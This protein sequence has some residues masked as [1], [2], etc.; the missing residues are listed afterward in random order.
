MRNTKPD[1]YSFE[2]IVY[3]IVSSALIGL[4]VIVYLLIKWLF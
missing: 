1:D 3:S 4:G 2:I